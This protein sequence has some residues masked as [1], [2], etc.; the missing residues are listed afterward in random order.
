M[1]IHWIFV[2]SVWIKRKAFFKIS[3]SSMNN[4]MK[5]KIRKLKKIIDLVHNWR[6]LTTLLNFW[7]IFVQMIIFRF[8]NTV[9][10]LQT[11]WLI[12][13]SYVYLSSYKNKSSFWSRNK[14]FNFLACK[15]SLTLLF[16]IE[17][18]FEESSKIFLIVWIRDQYCYVNL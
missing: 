2:L 9:S 13:S 3:K 18:M 4:E 6:N 8:L 16:E 1:A 11:F 12:N 10:G 5:R 15:I 17:K 7:M 14:S